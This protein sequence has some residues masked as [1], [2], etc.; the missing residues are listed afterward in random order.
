MSRHVVFGTGQ[1]GRHLVAHLVEVGHDVV[2]VNRSGRG[3]F[4]GA[5]VVGGDVAD[6]VFAKEAAHDADIVYFCLNAANYHRWPQEFPPLQAAVVGAASAHD[7]RLV[8]LENLYSYG[9]TG[10]AP[11][12]E[13]TALH[14]ENEKGATRAAM[15]QTLLEAHARGD[16]EVV[17]GRAA[18][19][20]GPGVTASSMGEFVFAPILAGK[21]AQ[22]MGRPDTEHTYS[23]AP[24]VGRNLALLGS[25][26][27]AY[28]RAWH[29]PNPETRTTRNIII[30]AYAAVGSRRT[31]VTALK[32]PMLRALGLFNHNIRELLHSYYQFAAPFVV[33][34]GAFRGAFGAPTTPWNEIID[35]T[36]AYYRAEELRLP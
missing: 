33:D 4:P 19:L 27:D 10:G 34:D 13:A 26:D 20:V 15:S 21:R 28:G 22:T 17:I 36:L 3:E 23:Y 18:D 25:A 14:P 29:L 9:K 2:A 24:D 35:K 11:M 31:D 30:D 12:T 32:R 6:P 1:V 5:R 8:V 16:L 7:A